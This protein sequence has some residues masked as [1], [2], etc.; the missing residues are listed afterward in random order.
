M[1][2][3]EGAAATVAVL[4]AVVTCTAMKS[5][6]LR[7]PPAQAVHQHRLARAALSAILA[8]RMRPLDG[9]LAAG[10]AT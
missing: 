2:V 1:R 6:E 5:A 10:R 8:L 7:E 4:A 3:R 9:Y